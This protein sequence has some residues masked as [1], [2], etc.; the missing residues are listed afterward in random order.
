MLWIVKEQEQGNPL[1]SAGSFSPALPRASL[2][3]WVGSDEDN[4]RAATPR[5]GHAAARRVV[6]G[7]WAV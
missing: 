6:G 3:S 2:A 1:G 7:T 4:A 5:V